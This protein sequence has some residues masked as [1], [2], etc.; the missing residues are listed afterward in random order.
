[1]PAAA[2]R[3]QR[4]PVSVDRQK[5][6]ARLSEDPSVRFNE[7]GRRAL[8]WLYHHSI[9]TVGIA[10]IEH[11]L[12]RHWSAE[13]ANLARSCADAWSEL[14]AQLQQRAVYDD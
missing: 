13:V 4:A 8:R 3:I 5:L 1:M 12:P 10:T 14:A 11:G 9:D 7:V 6:L 2:T